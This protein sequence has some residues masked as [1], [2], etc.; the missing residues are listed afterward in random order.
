M[1]D[2]EFLDV[3]E[4]ELRHRFLPPFGGKEFF[5]NDLFDFVL[6]KA[7][8]DL[9]YLDKEARLIRDQIRKYY[10]MPEYDSKMRIDNRKPAIKFKWYTPTDCRK[11]TITRG[12]IRARRMTCD[13]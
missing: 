10:D 8:E 13:E 3:I 9:S 12:K 5:N 11:I 2:T 1:N 7:G 4:A 6:D